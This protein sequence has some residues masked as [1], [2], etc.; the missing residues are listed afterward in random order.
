MINVTL[1][2]LL[3]IKGWRNYIIFTRKCHLKYHSLLY[4]SASQGH[5]QA[6]INWRKSQHCTGSSVNITNAVTAVV[7]LRNVRSHFPHAIFMYGVH[8]V[9][10][11]RGF[12]KSGV[13]PLY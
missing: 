9:F 10:L 3:C 6:A 5:R 8:V 12:L 2:K 11:V 13:C 7:V 4:L 1:T